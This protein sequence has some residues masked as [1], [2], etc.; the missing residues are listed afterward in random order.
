MTWSALR[1][2]CFADAR[3]SG[4]DAGTC[5]HLRARTQFAQRVIWME[6]QR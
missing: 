5:R 1:R 3:R 6:Q 4:H 2:A